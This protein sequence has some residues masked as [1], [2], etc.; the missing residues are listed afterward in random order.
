VEK[1]KG[2]LDAGQQVRHIALLNAQGK[3]SRQN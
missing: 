2:F 1:I 3:G